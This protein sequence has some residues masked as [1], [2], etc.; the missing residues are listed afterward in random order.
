MSFSDNSA[1]ADSVSLRLAI[2]RVAEVQG[3]L[4]L[5]AGRIENAVSLLVS[6]LG[7]EQKTFPDLQELDLARQSLENLGRLLT[8]LAEHVPEHVNV[9]TS[10]VKDSMNLGALI[11]SILQGTVVEEKQAAD[12]EVH[13]FDFG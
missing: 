7:P 4:A 1:K 12:S 8:T 11:G 2:S 6:S 3:A 13:L 10:R 9:P 5:S